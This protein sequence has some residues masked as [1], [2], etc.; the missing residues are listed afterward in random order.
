MNIKKTVGL[1]AAAAAAFAGLQASSASAKNCQPVATTCNT[2]SGCQCTSTGASAANAFG[3]ASVSSGTSNDTWTYRLN[4]VAG[5]TFPT[6]SASLINADG[7]TFTINV[8]STSGARC[9]PALDSASNID[10][11]FGDPKVCVTARAGTAGA[12][13]FLRISIPGN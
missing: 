5:P 8:L 10:G 3:K 6:R 9:Q 4:F 7:V 11:N 13:R 2:A 1:F 12:P